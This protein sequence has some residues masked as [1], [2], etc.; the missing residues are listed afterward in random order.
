MLESLRCLLCCSMMLAGRV[1]GSDQG[2]APVCLYTAAYAMVNDGIGWGRSRF[3]RDS[4]C[5]G[6]PSNGAWHLACSRLQHHS[7]MP[8]NVDSSDPMD[9]V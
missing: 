5:C 4:C 9:A 6:R 7:G 8:V 3:W 2:S 1:R